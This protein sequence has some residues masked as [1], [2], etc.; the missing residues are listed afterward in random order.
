MEWDRSSGQGAGLGSLPRPGP[1]ALVSSGPHLAVA[2]GRCR[3]WPAFPVA[4]PAHWSPG[5]V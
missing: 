2:S 4:A 1:A 3:L 5:C